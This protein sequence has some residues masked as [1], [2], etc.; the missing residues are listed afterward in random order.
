MQTPAPGGACSGW[1]RTANLLSPGPART[2]S[3][4]GASSGWRWVRQWG[5]LVLDDG[6]YGQW[7]VAEAGFRWDLCPLSTGTAGRLWVGTAGGGAPPAVTELIR[8]ARQHPV[9]DGVGGYLDVTATPFASSTT[10]GYQEGR[11]FP[12][13]W[14]STRSSFDYGF[15]ENMNMVTARLVWFR[16]RPSVRFEEGSSRRVWLKALPNA[17]EHLIAG[18]VV[19]RSRGWGAR[20]R[21]T[22]VTRLTSSSPDGPL[23]A[24]ANISGR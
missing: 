11:E 20:H 13:W 1:G 3:G 14:R 22:E 21:A 8:N 4:N 23:R 19:D 24:A 16:F 18:G 10:L 15:N 9:A 2:G 5:I 12:W 6:V 17:V 7:T